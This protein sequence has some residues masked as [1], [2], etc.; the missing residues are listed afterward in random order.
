MSLW[1]SKYVHRSMWHWPKKWQKVLNFIVTFYPKLS[2]TQPKLGTKKILSTSWL[3]VSNCKRCEC[4]LVR[5]LHGL[6]GRAFIL[7]TFISVTLWSCDV[8]GDDILVFPKWICQ[9]LLKYLLITPITSKF[10]RNIHIIDL[11]HSRMK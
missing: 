6:R 5:L 9:I 2:K 11:R 3:H 10:V 1:H 4:N 7:S 8:Q